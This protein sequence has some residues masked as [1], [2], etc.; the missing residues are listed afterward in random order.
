M[1]GFRGLGG[2]LGALE[3]F[4]GFRVFAGV[5]GVGYWGFRILG[6]SRMVLG[7]RK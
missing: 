1:E 4:R 5:K 6:V 2:V 3:R 7:S